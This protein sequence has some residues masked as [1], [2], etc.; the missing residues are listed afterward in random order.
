[1]TAPAGERSPRVALVHDYFTQRGG[2]ERV[3][4]HL[5]ALYPGTPLY[6]SVLDD[7][8]A[9][10]GVE[11]GRLHTSGLQRTRAMRLPLK[12]LAP[13]LPRSFARIDLGDADVVISSSSAFAHHVRPAAGRVHICYCHTPS[14][15]LW[16]RDEY[17]RAHRTAGRV[18]VPALALLR[19]WDRAAA[20]AVDVYIA[21]SRFTADRIR[22]SYGRDARIIHPPIDT[23][24]FVPTRE[25]SGRFL[26]VARL[27]PHKA[28]DLAIAAANQLGMALDVIGD[29]SD[30]QRLRAMAG[31][32]V[33]FLGRRTDAEVAHEMARCHALLV[34][35]VEDFGMAT[36]EVQ[37]AGRPAI[38]LAAGG[39]PE[40]VRD[41]T[42]GFLVAERTPEAFAAAMRRCLDTELDTGVLR[43]SAL[44]FDTR[45]FDHDLTRLVEQTVAERAAARPLAPLPAAVRLSPERT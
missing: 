22:A 41:G 11:R 15:F 27:R 31:P 2:A 30:L 8:A 42:T 35:G 10:D 19:H 16:N 21:N 14:A 17:F 4:Q 36:A 38:A 37:A 44:R 3:A 24:A 40:I 13:M 7:D 34:P 23:T 6:T 32:T 18:A 29:G 43:A 39:T 45:R 20:A 5:A 25:R 26:V 1:M 9:P 12:A 28:I 33:R